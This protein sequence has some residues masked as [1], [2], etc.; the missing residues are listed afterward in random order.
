M[1][2]LEDSGLQIAD[3]DYFTKVHNFRIWDVKLGDS[4]LRET[5]TFPGT[6]LGL[7]MTSMNTLI[8]ITRTT[9]AQQMM[10][11]SMESVM[12]PVTNI[13]NIKIQQQS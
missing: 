10:M 1:R 6:I 2:K 3:S 4:E 13:T 12:T 5:Y 8:G 11:N 9:S 7:N